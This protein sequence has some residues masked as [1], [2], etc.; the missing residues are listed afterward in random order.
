MKELTSFLVNPGVFSRIYRWPDR[1]VCVAYHTPT[2][3][4]SLMEGDSAEVWWHLFEAK[5]ATESALAYVLANGEFGDDPRSEALASL[6]EFRL[7]LE[8]SNLIQGPGNHAPTCDFTETVA[9]LTSPQ[10]DLQQAISRLMADRHVFYTLTLETTYRCNEKCVHCYLPEDTHLQELTLAQI[11]Q[12]MA[13]FHALGGFQLILTGGEVAVRKDFI[14]ILGLA[15][16]YGF[17][18][19]ILSNLTRLSDA[20]IANI[21]DHYPKSVSCSIYSA[22]PEDHDAVTRLQGSF[23]RS[24]KAIRMLREAGVIVAIKTPLMKH[25]AGGWQ[26]VEALAKQL[27][28]GF[29]MD[30]H[31]TAKNDGGLSPLAQRIE[32]SKVIQEVFSS[33]PY[34]I[35]IMNEPL[36]ND[37]T[38]DLTANLC[39]A[40]ANG[41]VISPDGTIRPCI[42]MSESIGQFPTNSL[43]SIWHESPFFNRWS[44]LTLADTLCGRCTFFST[45]SRCPGA[46]HAEHGSYTHPTDYNCFLARAWSRASQAESA[47]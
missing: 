23:D 2:H 25:T 3:S 27:G 1:T 33:P 9:D 45:C 29:Q 32:D 28:C 22:Q 21:I 19:S 47:S 37:I 40:G 36:Q 10:R 11:D 31:I 43:S 44:L 7:G 46:W 17:V 15:K 41:L 13:E 39:G 30:L 38:P 20:M 8:D 18:T 12:L 4:V 26:E 42:G 14:E 6:G 34:Q 5:G 24:L 16:K 35:T